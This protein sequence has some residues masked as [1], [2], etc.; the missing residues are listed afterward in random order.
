MSM[1]FFLAMM[2]ENSLYVAT[3]DPGAWYKHFIINPG[4]EFY[5]RTFPEDMGVPGSG[6]NAPFPTIIGVYQGDWMKG[7]K[8]YREFALTAPW[9]SEGKLSQRKSMP[10]SMKDIGIWIREKDWIGAGTDDAKG[11]IEEMKTVQKY[12]DVPVGLH[13]YNWHV[14]KFDTKYPYY[15]PVKKGVPE[16]ARGLAEAKDIVVMPYINGR[17]V[18]RSNDEFEDFKPYMIKGDD[19]RIPT[20][21]YGNRVPQAP[22]CPYTEFWQDIEVGVVERLITELGVNGVYIDQISAAPPY[23]CFDE[24]HGHPLGGGHWWVDAYR[25]LLKKVR[26]V[27]HKDGRAVLITSECTAEPYMDGI[28][29]FLIV[30]TK[31]A[32]SIPMLSAVYSG[33]TIYWGSYERTARFSDEKWVLN[34]GNDLVWGCQPGWMG[35]EV[36]KPGKE[37]K[38]AYLKILGKARVAGKKYLQYGELVDVFDDGSDSGFWGIPYIEGTI[39]KGEDGSLGVVIANYR[40]EKSTIEIEIGPGKYG[41]KS[42]SEFSITRIHPERK[43]VADDSDNSTIKLEEVLEPLEIRILEIRAK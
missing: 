42:G 37:K 12:L 15:F 32:N 22:A 18:D 19:G 41:I 26:E 4:T 16:I 33:Y 23:L 38:A 27:A 29:G 40:E 10:Q 5:V 3:H 34:L 39:W 6:Y 30:T 9:T 13:W 2:G 36:F 35:L 1:Q 14:S 25:T 43:P 20:E 21:R 8:I 28:D 11:K 7:C 17:I 24:S 31:N